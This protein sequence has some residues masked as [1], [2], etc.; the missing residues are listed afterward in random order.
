MIFIIPLAV[1]AIHKAFTEHIK[2]CST[3]IDESTNNNRNNR[4]NRD[5]ILSDTTQ[6]KHHN[7]NTKKKIIRVPISRKMS[8][9]N[10]FIEVGSSP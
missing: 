1:F 2:C 3:T 7:A 10:I 9:R 8:A 4:K 6:K 5:C